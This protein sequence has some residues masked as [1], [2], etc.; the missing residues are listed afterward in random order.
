MLKACAFGLLCGMA[1]G[2]VLVI[3][4][5]RG[6]ISLPVLVSCAIGALVALVSGLAAAIIFLPSDKKI[7]VLLDN[8]FSLGESVQ[9]MLAYKDE[10]GMIIDIQRRVTGERLDS[11]PSSGLKLKRIWT[12]ILCVAMSA[13]FLLTAFVVPA[14]AEPPV[15]D[16]IVDDYE[17]NWRIASLTALIARVEQDKFADQ[18]L[19]DGLVEEIEQLIEAVKATDKENVMKQAAVQTVVS[20]ESIFRYYNT[21]LVV[22]EAFAELENSEL[23]AFGNAL[24]KYDRSGIIDC[25]ESIAEQL[26]EGD[27]ETGISVFND[28][29]T[30]TLRRCAVENREES[31]Y[32]ALTAF[33]NGLKTITDSMPDNP[34]S[35]LRSLAEEFSDS[36]PDSIMLQRDNDNIYSIVRDE[37]ISIFGIV[38]EDF[39]GTDVK[40]PENSGDSDLVEPDDSDKDEESDGN[41]S[42]GYGVGEN[43]VGSDD[44]LYDP[45]SG[46][47]KKY[48]EMLNDYYE[49][50][51]N[52]REGMD[53][54]LSEEAGDY[55]DKLSTPEN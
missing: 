47:Y 32:V 40:V 19:K 39:E 2:S 44:V 27:A 17:K 55:F 4:F 51:D 6:V 15:E 30:S 14:V 54:E 20:A 7:A 9:T 1:V 25:I 18:G 38:K 53:E 11:I 16:P 10:S 52:A 8:E 41:N 24:V 28:I 12:L 49:K 46:E 35:E 3:L 31:F 45:D 26:G 34:A 42:G 5:K 37:I 43:L 36:I 48:A 13:A 21:A 29:M 22:G 50:Y 33:S 23:R